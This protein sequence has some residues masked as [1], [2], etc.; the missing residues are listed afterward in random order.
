MSASAEQ[1]EKTEEDALNDLSGAG[2][3]IGQGI[4]YCG[5]K[6]GFREILGIFYQEGC[7]RSRQLEQLFK[8]RDWNDYVITVHALKGN[9]RGIGAN[10]L[11]ELALHLEMAGKEG[12]VEYIET[13]HEEMMD[14]YAFLLRVLGDNAFIRQEETVHETEEISMQTLKERIGLLREKLDS[15]ESEG[16]AELL[17]QIGNSR[18]GDTTFS[19]LA[20]A[21]REK[22]EEFDFPG[23]AEALEAWEKSGESIR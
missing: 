19:G 9:A 6:E 20:E 14:K 4:A 12:R 8:E 11:S 18:C 2:I 15:F 3:N 1:A 16:L 10:E 22:T 21:V 7:K 23:A 13:H 5:D 17:E